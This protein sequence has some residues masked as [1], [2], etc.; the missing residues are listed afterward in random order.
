MSLIIPPWQRIDL[1]TLASALANI[2]QSS[3][4]LLINQ[5]CAFYEYTKKEMKK[6]L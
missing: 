6:L 1:T 5:N 2:F 3:M 4:I